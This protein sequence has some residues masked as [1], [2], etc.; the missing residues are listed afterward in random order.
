[1]TSENDIY[2]NLKNQVERQ[3]LFK[4]GFNEGIRKALEIINITFGKG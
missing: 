3:P 2:D 4:D 1:M